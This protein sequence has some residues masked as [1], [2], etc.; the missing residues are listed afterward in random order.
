MDAIAKFIAEQGWL[1]IWLLTI[2]YFVWMFSNGKL[3][4]IREHRSRVEDV[5]RES[6]ARVED[7]KERLRDEQ[8]SS[9]F[10]RE[11]ALTSA[12]MGTIITKAKVSMTGRRTDDS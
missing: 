3:I 4:S 6:E 1:G 10:W 12:E 2:S 5:L 8:K 11:A 7:L 9:E